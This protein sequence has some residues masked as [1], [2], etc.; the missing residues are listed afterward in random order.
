VEIVPPDDVKTVDFARFAYKEQKISQPINSKTIQ[1]IKKTTDKVS[2]DMFL[3][4]K[5]IDEISMAR[6]IKSETVMEHLLNNMP[7]DAI[8]FDKFMTAETY[9]H[10]KDAYN[11]LG[12]ES[13]LKVMKDHLPR[14]ISYNQIKVVKNLLF[15]TNL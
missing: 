14:Y 10:I 2:L 4:G 8:T 5:T 13:S 15:P 12:N 9:E 7:N 3:E 11:V 1:V 6:R